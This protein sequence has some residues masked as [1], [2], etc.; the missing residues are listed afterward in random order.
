M[1]I[2]ILIFVVVT[3]LVG[4]AGYASSS[5]WL[6]IVTGGRKVDPTTLEIIKVALPVVGG[7]GV[8]AITALASYRI[9][10]KKAGLDLRKSKANSR[11]AFLEK[12]QKVATDYR[13]MVGLLRRGEFR[14][15]DIESLEPQL[16][17][18]RDDLD[19]DG[20]LYTSWCEF[21][22]KGVYLKERAAQLTTSPEWDR[23]WK[24]P[25]PRRGLISWLIGRRPLGKSFG[26]DAERVLRLIKQEHKNLS[27]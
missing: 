14:R 12:S 27:I 10:E 21:Y 9:E 6:P 3:I 4:A 23:L 22:Q 2:L 18:I 13:E 7:I 1:A 24:E 16:A 26:R 5:L 11:V 17:Q 8:A 25:E 19:R 15:A 20:K